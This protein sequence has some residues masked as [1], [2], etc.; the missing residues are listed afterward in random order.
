MIDRDGQRERLCVVIVPAEAADFVHGYLG[1][2]TPLAHAIIGEQAG[3]V[4]PYLKG[5]IQA[6]EIIEVTKEA[7]LPSE[8]A[9]KRR[10][11]EMKKTLKEV[12]NTSAMLFASSFSGKWGDYD[13]NSIPREDESKASNHD[14]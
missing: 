8:D 3:E 10:A 2:N 9:A 4:I 1:I 12:Q 6:I 7:Q 14:Q 11:E 5:D 13:P